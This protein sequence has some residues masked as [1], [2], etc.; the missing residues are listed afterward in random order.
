MSCISNNLKEEN[1]DDFKCA[2][3]DDRHFFIEPITLPNCGHAVCK[4]CLLL[5]SLQSS[6]TSVKCKICGCETH[7]PDF[8][9][10]S[11]SKPLTQAIKFCIGDILSILEKEISFNLELLKGLIYIRYFS[12]N[13]FSN[14]PEDFKNRNDLFELK[15]KFY[16]EEIDICVESL[17]L[18]LEEAG[19]KQKEKLRDFER[20]AKIA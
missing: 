4:D 10:L 5:E 20:K 7:W 9:K 11:V 8:S 19:E 15:K 18:Q 12:N 14:F 13:N 3:S 1:F 16:E 6:V 2:L 17:K